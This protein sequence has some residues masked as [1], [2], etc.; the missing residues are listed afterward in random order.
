MTRQQQSSR[1]GENQRQET[2]AEAL[3]DCGE[4]DNVT[5]SIQNIKR[6][7]TYHNLTHGTEF[8]RDVFNLSKVDVRPH[9][10][11]RYVNDNAR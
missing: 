2:G 3:L 5:N 4:Y 11:V 6:Q 7:H 9:H 1:E 8:C 10:H